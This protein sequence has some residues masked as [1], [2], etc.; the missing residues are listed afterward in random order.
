MNT[1]VFNED[2]EKYYLTDE[3]I[4]KLLEQNEQK[5][6]FFGFSSNEK[7]ERLAQGMIEVQPGE[8]EW[9]IVEQDD[10]Y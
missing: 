4:A 9:Q 2:T 3:L 8:G 6:T 5:D 10:D 1:L 7:R